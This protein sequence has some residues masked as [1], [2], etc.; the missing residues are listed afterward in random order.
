MGTFP[1][2]C[3]RVGMDKKEVHQ[4]IRRQVWMVFFLPLGMAVLHM[5]A[6]FPLV[7]RLL[8]LMN[9]YQTSLYIVLHIGNHTGV[10]PGIRDYLLD[11][12]QNL[13][14]DCELKDC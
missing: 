12:G 13:L 8:A 7:K 4:S 3:R 9:L 6:A 2:L 5:A 10:C 14:P 1:D 11:Y